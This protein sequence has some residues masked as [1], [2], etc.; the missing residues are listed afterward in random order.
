MPKGQTPEGAGMRQM[1]AEFIDIYQK[2]HRFP[3]SYREIMEVTG[4]KSTSTVAYHVQ[5]LRAEGVLKET[6]GKRRS[7]ALIKETDGGTDSAD[8]AAG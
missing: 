7:L 3:P 5:K 8:S 6:K 2:E 1:I 4:I